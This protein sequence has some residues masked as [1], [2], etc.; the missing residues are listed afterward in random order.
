MLNYTSLSF[1]F[2]FTNDVMATN[3]NV[4]THS[5]GRIYTI[6]FNIR[7]FY[8]H[9]HPFFARMIQNRSRHLN[10]HTADKY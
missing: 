4:R 2:R 1:V 9:T 10:Y 8:V 5:H 6:R 3:Q 7:W